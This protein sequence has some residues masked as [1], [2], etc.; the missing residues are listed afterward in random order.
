MIALQMHSDKMRAEEEAR[1]RGASPEEI[2]KAGRKAAKRTGDIGMR[3]MTHGTVG[4]VKY[5]FKGRHAGP[6]GIVGG[7]I[8]GFVKGSF[9]GAMSYEDKDED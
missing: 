4:S 7:A 2:E 8:L 3:M 5:G 1:A 6:V 9:D